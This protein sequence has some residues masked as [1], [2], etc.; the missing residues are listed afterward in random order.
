MQ[1]REGVLYH[2]ERRTHIF[3]ADIEK[4]ERYFSETTMYEDFALTDELFH[5]QSQNQTRDDKGVGLDYIHH[6]ERGKQIMLFIRRNKNTPE[7]VTAPY[8]FLGPVEYV[9]HEGSR[10]MSIVWKMLHPIPAHVLAW[11]RKTER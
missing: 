8:I 3:F 4:H 2:K 11:A 5:W 1:S 9:R 10:P 6:K 7:G